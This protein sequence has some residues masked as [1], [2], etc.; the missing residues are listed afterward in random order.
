MSKSFNKYDINFSAGIPQVWASAD[1][2]CILWCNQFMVRLT[3]AIYDIVNTTD[4]SK[5]IPFQKRLDFMKNRF[6]STV[7]FGINF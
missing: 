7:K 4:P 2:K 5:T 6:S 1:H 3:E